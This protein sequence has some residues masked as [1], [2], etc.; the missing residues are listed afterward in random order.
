MTLETLAGST[1]QSSEGIQD[2][3]LTDGVGGMHNG[4]RQKETKL[5]FQ[6]IKH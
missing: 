3:D 4:D 2:Y 6:H 5:L 1:F